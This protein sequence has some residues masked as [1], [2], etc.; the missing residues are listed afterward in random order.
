MPGRFISDFNIDASPETVQ[1]LG[2]AYAPTSLEFFTSVATLHPPVS[3]QLEHHRPDHALTEVMQLRMDPRTAGPGPWTCSTRCPRLS[4][5]TWT[6]ATTR[7]RPA[8][9]WP[10]GDLP[11]RP[12]AAAGCAVRPRRF[13]WR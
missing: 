1:L 7:A 5:C 8:S 9:N 4:R 11:L 12:P 3:V 13:E 6:A 10:S 2:I